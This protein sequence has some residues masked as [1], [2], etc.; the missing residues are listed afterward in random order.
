VLIQFGSTATGHMH[1]RSDVDLG[2]WFERAPGSLMSEAE[3]AADLQPH[4]PGR[5]VDLAV[6][7]HADPLFLKQV[8][9][10][11]RVLF[12]TPS[13][14]AELR[15]YAFKRYVDHRRFLDMERAYVRRKV[16]AER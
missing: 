15:L 7:N 13:D 9:E 10:R 6:L 3:V 4:F 5:E 12:G 11:S 14:V 1:V 16:G 2:A 8:F